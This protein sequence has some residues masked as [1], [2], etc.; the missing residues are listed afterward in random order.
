MR[1][2]LIIAGACVLAVLL[3]MFVAP[4]ISLFGGMPNFPVIVVMLVAI[5]QAG[6][7]GPVVPFVMGLV[8]DF[9]SGGPL[10]AMSF[11]LTLWSVAASVIFAVAD[12]DTLFMPIVAILVGLFFT[13]LSYGVFLQIMGYNAGFF[14]AVVYRVLP[15]FVYDGVI[16]ALLFPLVRRLFSPP[17]PVQPSVTQL[18]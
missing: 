9:M 13:E 10:G 15:C 17:M 12:N 8:F 1:E 2:R 4:Y 11:S 3:Q 7:Y 14:Q 5:S 6:S 18:R 16:A